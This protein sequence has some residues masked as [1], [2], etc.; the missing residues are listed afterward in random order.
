M[1]DLVETQIGL[2]Q[3]WI[4]TANKHVSQIATPVAAF[5][6]QDSEE[7]GVFYVI[8]VR[9]VD[10]GIGSREVPGEHLY[11]T[12]VARVI[13]DDIWLYDG[14]SSH[15][16]NPQETLDEILELEFAY[17]SGDYEVPPE[18]T[19]EDPNLPCFYKWAKVSTLEDA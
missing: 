13:D 14:E 2:K 3:F 18:A 11:Q 12:L 5:T 16:L 4:R 8:E 1:V 6:V 10:E 15:G 7:M 17:A 19:N 9:S